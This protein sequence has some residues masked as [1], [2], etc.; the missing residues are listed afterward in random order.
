MRDLNLSEKPRGTGVKAGGRLRTRVR[1][2]DVVVVGG[3]A[4]RGGNPMSLAGGV[5]VHTA[6]EDSTPRGIAGGEVVVGGRKGDGD[7]AVRNLA[8]EVQL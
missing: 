2:T 7:S 1:G 4:I 3:T 5:Q 8:Q 6:V